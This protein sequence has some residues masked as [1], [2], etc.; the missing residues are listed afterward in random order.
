MFRHA[1]TCTC[2]ACCSQ[3]QG[4]TSGSVRPSVPLAIHSPGLEPR[5]FTQS[6]LGLGHPHKCFADCQREK[7]ERVGELEQALLSPGPAPWL[8]AYRAKIQVGRWAFG[9]LPPDPYRRAT[10]SSTSFVI[11]ASDQCTPRETTGKDSWL[12]H[13]DPCPPCGR[14]RWIP[15]LS[16]RPCWQLQTSSK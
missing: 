11:S 9:T 15:Q 3:G 14:P 13:L 4:D 16:A 10:S 7:G 12:E 2:T 6:F 5:C 1:H 8:L